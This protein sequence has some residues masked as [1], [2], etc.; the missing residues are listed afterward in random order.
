M[1]TTSSGQLPALD[2]DAIVRLEQGLPGGN[3]SSALETFGDELEK[4][5]VELHK[6]LESDD[7]S[8]LSSLAHG[9]KGSASTFCAPVLAS[10]ALILEQK[11]AAHD[12][13]GIRVATGAVSSEIS[14]VVRHLRELLASRR[15]A[16]G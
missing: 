15:R 11:L 9:L 3:I 7:E 2:E 4:R 14:R 8:G 6:L 1:M 13:Q 16:R 10:A 5:K 12:T